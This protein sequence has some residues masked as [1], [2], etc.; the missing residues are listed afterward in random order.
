MHVYVMYGE[1]ANVC[2]HVVPKGRALMGLD[3]MEVFSVNIVGNRVCAVFTAP[4]QSSPV[5]EPEPADQ[6]VSQPAH[7]PA[8]PPGVQPAILGFQHRV[9]VNP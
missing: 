8:D 4:S 5:M 7:S 1:T 2:I 9:T 6:S 3:L